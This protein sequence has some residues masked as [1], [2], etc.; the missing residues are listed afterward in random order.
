MIEGFRKLVRAGGR[1]ILRGWILDLW[2]RR[3]MRRL[4]RTYSQNLL[5]RSQGRPA[6]ETIPTLSR[7]AP[8]RRLLFISDVHWEAKQLV[9]ELQKIAPVETINFR[10][11]LP[12]EGRTGDP[13]QVITFLREQFASGS[14]PEPDAILFYARSNLLSEEVF[15]LIRK[16]WSCPLM[17]MNLDDKI[18]FLEYGLLSERSDNYQAWARF[19]DL[20]LTNVRAVADWY[21]DRGCPVH[22]LPE[23]FHPRHS[24]PEFPAGGY[25]HEISFVGQWKPEREILFRRLQQMGLPIEPVGFGWPDDAA[26]H[27]PESV[28]RTSMLNLGM[29]FASPSHALTTLKTRDFECPGSGGCYLTTFNWE[30]GL[31]FEIGREILCYRSNEELVEIF[32]FYRRRPEACF[33]IA[34]AGYQRCLREHTWEKRFRGVFQKAGFR[35]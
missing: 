10:P 9:P 15:E 22:Y 32:S 31:H 23:G 14:L 30:L 5:D 26:G 11:H 27:D 7:G 33:Q 3:K 2:L 1:W 25:R 18:E 17:G 6:N 29:G 4:E 8:L 13:K 19:F 28:Y 35:C 12:M 21:A 20:N 24:P 16:R 34:L